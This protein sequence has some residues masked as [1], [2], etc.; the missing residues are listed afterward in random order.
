M[1]SAALPGN[2]FIVFSDDWG[3]HPS[4]CQHL[5]RHLLARHTVI[6]VNT[7][8]MRTPRFSL[9]DLKK[10][11]R[12]VSKMFM[13]RVPDAAR[14][15]TAPQPQVCQPFMLP[16]SSIAAVRRFNRYSV[17]RQVRRVAR[18]AN[19][20]RPVVVTT[21][22]NACDYVDGFD[23]ARIVYYCVDDFSQWPGLE[24]ALVRDM[25][26]SLIAKA[27]LL[28]ATSRNLFTKLSAG[29]RKVHLLTHGVDL[30]LFSQEA[31]REHACLAAIPAPRAGYFGLFDQRSDQALLAAVARAN[32]GISFVI[33][34]PVATDTALLRACPNIH[35]TGPLPYLELPA[36]IKG[37][38][39]LFIPYV[40]DP[41]TDSISPLKL[42][43]YLVT[44]K[45]VVV[46]PIAEARLQPDFLSLAA[47]AAEWQHAL[48]AA[49]TADR[50]TR[51]VAVRAALAGESWANKAGVFEGLC[52]PPDPSL[53]RTLA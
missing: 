27:D 14:D 1:S 4:S 15:A 40:V 33:T 48:Q 2:S 12:K 34:G 9:A 8:G 32:P 7:I 36:L 10:I 39:V 29:G 31:P 53:P 18:A 19:V 37:L 38:D 30:E 23:A 6:W 49:L 47:T 44:G 11:V 25:E 52:N 24:H 5:F 16:F 3:E 41:F 50:S 45:P 35:F 28:I 17:L 42:K 26:A 51:R 46:T 13:R 22:P 20:R 43:E 21:V